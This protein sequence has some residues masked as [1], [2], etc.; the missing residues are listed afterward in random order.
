VRLNGVDVG[1]VDAVKLE[2]AGDRV[3]V[4]LKIHRNYRDQIRA[5]S[6]AY[7]ADSKSADAP[8]L[9]VVEVYNSEGA[10]PLMPPN[11]EIR[12]KDS[13]LEL[14]AWQ[15][16]GQVSQ[17]SNGLSKAS[18]ELS[19]QAREM[20]G[21]AVKAIHGVAEGIKQ[22]LQQGALE[23]MAGSDPSAS[24][25]AP[26]TS[27]TLTRPLEFDAVA[28]KMKKFL[29][30]MGAGGKEK[31][32]EL[33]RKWDELKKELVP[34]LQKLKAA[35]EQMLSEQLSEIQREI[36]EEMERLRRGQYDQEPMPPV[37]GE[38]VKI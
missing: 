34:A 7:I 27:G 35:G 24:S 33:S 1:K 6:T 10:T 26:P 37:K 5:D 14:K 23:A 2:G 11:K 30:E 19:R 17:W 9:K 36:E 12:G 3:A 18:K 38:P 8:G 31:L 22:G 20:T 21:E 29:S 15:L 16:N 13:L 25:A 28:D 32:A 4:R